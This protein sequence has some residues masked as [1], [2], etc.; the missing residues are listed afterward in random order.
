MR[1][2]KV[3]VYRLDELKEETREKAIND[4]WD[5]LQDV[6]CTN[7]LPEDIEYR[8]NLT[9]EEIIYL[10]DINEYEFFENGELI[11]VKYYERNIK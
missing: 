2:I 7:D 5:F 1:Q 9:K 11:P 6:S 3:N 8:G 10:I 4:H